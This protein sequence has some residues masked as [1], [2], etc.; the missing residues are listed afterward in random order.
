MFGISSNDAD[1][2]SIII[3]IMENTKLTKRLIDML[4]SRGRE[5][6]FKL[7][8]III[9][10]GRESDKVYIVE[11][12]YVNVL[13]KDPMGNDVLV[14]TAGPGSILGEVGIF[15][16]TDR[17]ATVRA[18]S[19]IKT[20]SF[21]KEEFLRVISDIPEVAYYIISVLVKRLSHLNKRLINAISSKL[22]LITGYY[23]LDT[24]ERLNKSLEGNINLSLDLSAVSFEIGVDAEKILISIANFSK[25]GIVENFQMH[26]TT[27]KET[28][29]KKFSVEFSFATSK[30]KSYLKT[31]S[32]INL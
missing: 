23:I 7:G 6:N 12:G 21:T 30:M 19:D 2:R 32:A 27:D 14:G 28:G 16:E 3:K 25:A 4:R 29:A 8:E 10:E 31:I 24:A 11:K 26:E 5:E 17:T 18:V 1:K 9:E 22:M 20:I 15:M 13:K